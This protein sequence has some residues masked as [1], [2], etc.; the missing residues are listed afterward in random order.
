MLVIPSEFGIGAFERRVPLGLGLLNTVFAVLDNCCSRN[1]N[2]LAT[3]G[4]EEM[5][6][7]NFEK[8]KREW[9]SRCPG[10]EEED[11][12]GHA[13]SQRNPR[14]WLISIIRSSLAAH[15]R[16]HRP[17]PCPFPPTLFPLSNPGQSPPS[18]SLKRTQPTAPQTANRNTSRRYHKPDM[19]EKRYGYV[20]IP[21]RLPALIMLRRVLGFYS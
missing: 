1:V 7:G 20:P 18:H 6:N 5:A 17:D 16:P 15:H 8:P 4:C 10:E 21:M 2:F 9:G 3:R 12:S 11:T 19:P 13:R 14:T